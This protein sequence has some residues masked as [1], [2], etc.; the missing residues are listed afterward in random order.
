MQFISNV[1]DKDQN[2]QKEMGQ[3]PMKLIAWKD[4]K[5]N[6]YHRQRELRKFLYEHNI[7]LLAM[8]EHK[9]NKK[10]GEA[11]IKR[12]VKGW[13]RVANHNSQDKGRMLVLRNP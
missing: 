2:G 7:N 10:H 3:L 11:I 12:V 6:K 5:L 8:V 9:V 4:R 13:S 1:E